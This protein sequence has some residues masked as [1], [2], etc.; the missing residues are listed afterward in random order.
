MGKNH[1]REGEQRKKGREKGRVRE[2]GGE[3]KGK[4]FAK[5]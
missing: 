5:A 3:R 2:R 4:D 1:L